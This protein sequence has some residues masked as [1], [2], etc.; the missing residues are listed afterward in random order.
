MSEDA[1]TWNVFVG[2]AEETKQQQVLALAQPGWTVSRIAAAVRVDR[3]TVT[4][5]CCVVRFIQLARA[6]FNAVRSTRGGF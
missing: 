5:G 2:L 4:Q 3:A 6:T 1:L